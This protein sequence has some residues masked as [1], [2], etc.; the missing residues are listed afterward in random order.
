[1]VSVYKFNCFLGGFSMFIGL[2]G[3]HATMFLYFTVQA[4][5]LSMS[6][7]EFYHHLRIK[8]FPGFSL[9]VLARFLL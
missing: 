2:S 4:F 8:G 9:D 5:L 6:Q 7:E 3:R 1:M